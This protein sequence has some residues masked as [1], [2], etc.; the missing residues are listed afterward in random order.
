MFWNRTFPYSFLWPIL[1]RSFEM[2]LSIHYHPLFKHGVPP[3]TKSKV[4]GGFPCHITKARQEEVAAQAQIGDRR[5]PLF[6]AAI[7]G[8][9][10]GLQTKMFQGITMRL[11]LFWRSVQSNF[12]ASK[13]KLESGCFQVAAAAAYVQFHFRVLVTISDSSHIRTHRSTGQFFYQPS[14]IRGKWQDL[15]T[16]KPATFLVFRRNSFRG[17]LFLLLSK[18]AHLTNLDG[19][20]STPQNFDRI[21]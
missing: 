20:A 1:V 2:F 9:L 15:K 17:P 14:N 8:T 18:N 16:Q 19:G 10:R 5:W 21:W 12:T 4:P 3:L 7:I 13:A 6:L 11:P